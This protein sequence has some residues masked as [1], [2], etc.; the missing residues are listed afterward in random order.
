MYS[1]DSIKKILFSAM[2]RNYLTFLYV[3]HFSQQAVMN[4][5][6]TNVFM[7]PFFVKLLLAMLLEA[8][9][10]RTSTE[11]ELQ[12]AFPNFNS[13]NSRFEIRD[14]YWRALTSFRVN[15]TQSIFEIWMHLI[16][17]STEQN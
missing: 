14:S 11:K 12:V 15:N 6:K 8:S 4:N 16:F 2:F 3:M 9:G 1:S 13:I 5:D 10:P 7:S 17:F